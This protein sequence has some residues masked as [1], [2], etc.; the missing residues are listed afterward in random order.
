MYTEEFQTLYEQEE[1][2]SFTLP[3]HLETVSSGLF[4]FGVLCM[5]FL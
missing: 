2:A 4:G 1:Q 5:L 3:S